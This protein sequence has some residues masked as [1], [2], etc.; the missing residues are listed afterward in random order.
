MT[1]VYYYSRKKSEMLSIDYLIIKIDNSITVRL[2]FNKV[3]HQI[4]EW[5]MAGCLFRHI[6]RQN[7][8]VFVLTQENE[9]M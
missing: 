3:V 7:M 2:D 5:K 6:L 4:I 9:C 1:F 8:L